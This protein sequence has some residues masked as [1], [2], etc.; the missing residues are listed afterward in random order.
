MG[1]EEVEKIKKAIFVVLKHDYQVKYSVLKK[2]LLEFFD[3]YDVGNAFE[4]LEDEGYIEICVF[5]DEE[6]VEPITLDWG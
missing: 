5:D 2:T 1:H 6:Y 4:I 3:S